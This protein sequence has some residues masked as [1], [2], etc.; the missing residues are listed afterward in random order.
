MK[1]S[2][3]FA[4]ILAL[5]VVPAT[6]HPGH[7]EVSSETEPGTS[8]RV[9]LNSTHAAVN[10]SCGDWLFNV[11]PKLGK[12]EEPFQVRTLCKHAAAAI[13]F[14]ATRRLAARRGT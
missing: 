5:V 4:E 8:H 6:G 9:R 13:F 7:Y 12:G 2:I 11:E 1:A 10:C 14:E 3:K